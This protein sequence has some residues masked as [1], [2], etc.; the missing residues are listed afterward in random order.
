[1]NLIA[2]R[3]QGGT[4]KPL[5]SRLAGKEPL[6]TRTGRRAAAADLGNPY[7]SVYLLFHQQ[8]SKRGVR[9]LLCLRLLLRPQPTEPLLGLGAKIL[10]G[11]LAQSEQHRFSLGT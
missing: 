2:W 4:S 6:R 5:D 1:M 8:E 7:P 10:A 9:R 3:R 11:Q